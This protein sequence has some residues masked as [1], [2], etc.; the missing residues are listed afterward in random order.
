MSLD[1]L[2]SLSLIIQRADEHDSL[3]GIMARMA[4]DNFIQKHSLT[5]INRD[6][7][8]NSIAQR[9]HGQIAQLIYEQEESIKK[10]DP[11]LEQDI[12]L[13]RNQR[14]IEQRYLQDKSKSPESS[15]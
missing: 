7:V 2:D 12:I 3:L 5:D 14:R 4:V 9:I 10:A 15:S 11:G 6:Q 13:S 1:N 8:V